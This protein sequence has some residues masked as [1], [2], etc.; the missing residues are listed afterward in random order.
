MKIIEEFNEDF[1]KKDKRKKNILLTLRL[2]Y[3]P[4]NPIF[5]KTIT[6][7]IGVNPNNEML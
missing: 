2:V 6:G 5:I 1:Y 7:Q 4:I 3:R